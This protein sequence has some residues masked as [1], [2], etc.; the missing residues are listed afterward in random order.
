MS[1]LITVIPVYNG[2]RFLEATLE[3]VVSQTR[4]PDLVI[5]QDNCSTDGTHRIAQAFEK[6]G[7]EWRLSDEHVSSTDNFNAALR[8]AEETD[9][10]HL[11]T[12]D[13]LIKPEF[14]ERLLADYPQ[15]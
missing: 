13:D 3:S 12:A 6:E 4:R 10:L 2:E 7:F 11:L 15:S 8:F 9:V 14:Y 1:R 5:I